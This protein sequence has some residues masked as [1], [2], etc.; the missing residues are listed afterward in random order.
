MYLL[1]RIAEAKNY[2]YKY[3]T[4]S[5]YESYHDYDMS[6]FCMTSTICTYVHMLACICVHMHNCIAFLIALGNLTAKM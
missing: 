2:T 4:K 6:T 3:V 5:A 1:A